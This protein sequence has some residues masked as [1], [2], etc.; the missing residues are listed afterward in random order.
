MICE[1]PA[2]EVEQDEDQGRKTDPELLLMQRVN[3]MLNDLPDESSI[4]R[5]VSYLYSRHVE[6]QK[7][8]V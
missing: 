4:A 5:V 8:T 3:R 7:K 6:A 1:V 2:T